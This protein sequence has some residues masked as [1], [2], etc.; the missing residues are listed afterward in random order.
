[1][2]LYFEKFYC[3]LSYSDIQQTNILDAEY[4][5]KYLIR[6][7]EWRKLK[8]NIPFPFNFQSHDLNM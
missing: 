5:K 1:M 3:H 8:L 2:S 4:D 6:E 7:S